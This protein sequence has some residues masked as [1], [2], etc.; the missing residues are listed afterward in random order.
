M[1][2]RVGERKRAKRYLE[3]ITF[4]AG[5]HCAKILVGHRIVEV[6]CSCI[7]RSPTRSRPLQPSLL[8]DLTIASTLQSPQYQASG[9]MSLLLW[10]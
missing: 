4:H 6:R 10:V 7:R 5:H 9:S 1:G 8:Q 3:L 2:A